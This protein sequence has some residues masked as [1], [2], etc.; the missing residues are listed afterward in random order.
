MKHLAAD[1]VVVAAGTAGLPAAVTAAQGGARV[2][3]CEKSDTTGGCPGSGQ[4]I[5][6]ESGLQKQK[7]VKLT[8]KELFKLHMD[9]IHWRADARL[10]KAF[11]DESGPTIDW[12]EQMGIVFKLEG[13]PTQYTLTCRPVGSLQ[14]R[15]DVLTNKAKETGVQILLN[16]PVKHLIKKDNRITG[17]VAEDN[18]GEEVKIQAGAVI[19]ATGGFGDNPDMIKKYTG[20]D[21]GQNFFSFRVPGLSGDGIRMAWDIG[22]AESEMGMQ[23]FYGMPHP[24]GGTS[25]TTAELQAFV[26][27]NLMVNLN[28]ERFI[29]EE[30]QQDATFVGNNIARQRNRC[31]FMIFDENT[32]DYYVKSGL[33]IPFPGTSGNKADKFDATLMEAKRQGYQHLFVAE[34][35]D[36]LC[37]QTSI[38]LNGLEK[39]VNEYNKCCENGYDTIFQKDPK[40]LKPVKQSKFYA[41]RFF[42]RAYGST[43]G[44]KINHKTE[45]LNR[46]EK[47]IPGLYA[48]GVDAA[49]IYGDS[50]TWSLFGN[51]SGFATNSGRIA[52]RNAME[53]I[54]RTGK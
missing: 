25:R 10:V 29:S 33:D 5:A 38:D 28:G 15:V 43:G 53:Y 32:R 41:A 52:G 26:Q 24:Y 8:R 54:K 22:A 6:V 9:Y 34:S 13:G 18:T 35:L 37:A 44:I 40:F 50:Y 20:F 36:D 45:V 4:I 1:I 49:A 47:A 12:L 42:P 46:E 48:A 21:W 16:T 51:P 19:V 11:Y 23:L 17:V 7:G 3:I 2:I 27:P 31:A 30:M 39:T 14:A